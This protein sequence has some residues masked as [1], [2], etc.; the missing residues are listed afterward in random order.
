MVTLAELYSYVKARAKTEFTP[1]K[2]QTISV[3]PAND[4]T[5]ILNHYD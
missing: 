4:P 1:V 2:W 5:A 3:W